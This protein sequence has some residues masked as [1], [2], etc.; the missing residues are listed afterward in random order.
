MSRP[1]LV[2][3]H[4]AAAV[5]AVVVIVTFLTSSAVTELIGTPGE[6]R[7]LRHGI[8]LGL[9]LLIGCLATAA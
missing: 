1:L 2:R 4:L 7:L 5:A 6:V 9:P 8:M 3:V